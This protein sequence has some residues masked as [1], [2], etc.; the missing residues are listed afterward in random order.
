MSANLEQLSRAVRE[1]AQS[2]TALV[3]RGGASKAFYGRAVQGPALETTGLHGIVEYEPSELVVTVKAGT[4][5]AELEFALAEKGQML[6]FEPPYFAPS[7]TVGGVVATGLSGPA[8]AYRGSVRDFV[9]GLEIIDGK[10][11]VLRFGGKVIK[12]V[13]GYDVSRLMVGANGTLGVIT[14]VSFKVLPLPT[15]ETTL[16][17]SMDEAAALK[18]MNE[19]A[20]K[21][22][23]LSATCF[24][25]GHLWVRLSGSENGVNAAAAKLGGEPLANAKQFWHSVREQSIMPAGPRLW[26]FAVPATAPALGLP[27]K[28]IIEWGGAQR[29]LLSDELST[30][31]IRE[32]ALRVGGHG[33]LFRGAAPGEE[34]FQPLASGIATIHQR[35]KKTF[36]PVGILNRGRMYDGQ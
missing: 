12:N 17:F 29:W 14:E 28:Q 15:C 36:D 22:L 16:Q 4:A 19:W 5:L 20:G 30:A 34:V 2:G 33:T 35:L 10:G 6:P 9:L 18:I 8:R 23:P 32:T 31:Q 25:D 24:A 11:D 13:A 3:I 1:A 26:R 7:A 21:P 27:G